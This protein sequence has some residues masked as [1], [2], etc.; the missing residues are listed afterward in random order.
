MRIIKSS[1]ELLILWW[2]DVTLHSCFTSLSTLASIIQQIFFAVGWRAIKEAQF[3]KAIRAL[4]LPGLTFVGGA[5]PVDMAL[6]FIRTYLQT[7]ASRPSFNASPQSS[8]V[9]I[10]W[11]LIFSFGENSSIVLTCYMFL[12]KP[13]G[14][15]IYL[16]APGDFAPLGWA[17]GSLESAPSP[18]FSQS[19]S[20]ASLS[21]SWTHNFCSNPVWPLS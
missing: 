10:P 3:N 2:T 5:H 13:K 1:R 16:Q 14:R 19:F 8:G 17:T 12:T 9:T 18:K 11:H 7:L 15:S 21:G 4:S 6:F 20:R